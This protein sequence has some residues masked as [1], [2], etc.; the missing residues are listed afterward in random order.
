MEQRPTMPPRW[1][2]AYSIGPNVRFWLEADIPDQLP[3]MSARHPKA[4][5]VL[6]LWRGLL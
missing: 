6:R 2:P 5:M 4:D 1:L 3:P